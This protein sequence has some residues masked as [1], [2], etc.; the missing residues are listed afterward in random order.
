MNKFVEMATFKKMK[1]VMMLSKEHAWKTVVAH[2]GTIH[3]LF[4]QTDI[5]LNA[6]L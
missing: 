5:H 6:L 2:L 1:V 4:C 3:A